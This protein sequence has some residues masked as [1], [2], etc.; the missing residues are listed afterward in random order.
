MIRAKGSCYQSTP[1]S[2]PSI[3][4]HQLLWFRESG[5]R[6]WR[7]AG[8]TLAP[9]AVKDLLARKTCFKYLRLR[10]G[11][12]SIRKC[13]RRRFPR[14]GLCGRGRHSA[15]TG[16]VAWLRDSRNGRGRIRTLF[17][18]ALRVFGSAGVATYREAQQRAF[19]RRDSFHAAELV[20]RLIVNVRVIVPA[21]LQR[22]PTRSIHAR[23][24]CVRRSSCT[25]G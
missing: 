12:R 16:R 11:A 20:G 25:A 5:G 17:A 1:L 21:N 3:C 19:A 14:P 4:R 8:T 23:A 10:R 13:C 9:E 18:L 6:R 2:A 7:T 22:S 24:G 15:A